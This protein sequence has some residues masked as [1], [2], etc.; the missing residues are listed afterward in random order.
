MNHGDRP[1]RYLAEEPIASALSDSPSFALES[2][3]VSSLLEPD[4]GKP[5][6]ERR[7]GVKCEEGNAQGLA[8]A[9]VAS[10]DTRVTPRL[11]ECGSCYDQLSSQADASESQSSGQWD[12]PAEGEDVSK[13]GLAASISRV[14]AGW[15]C[16]QHGAD[17]PRPQMAL[18]VTLRTEPGSPRRWSGARLGPRSRKWFK[19]RP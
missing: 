2:F 1:C 8:A 17:G 6:L 14:Q 10:L 4:Q 11:G 9:V 3:P 12:H 13:R 5:D 15:A 7:Q 19:R 16:C 18:L